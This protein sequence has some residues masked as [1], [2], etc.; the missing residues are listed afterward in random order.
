VIFSQAPHPRAFPAEELAELTQRFIGKNSIVIHE[1]RK[2][3]NLAR[4][5]ARP[6]ELILITGS[7]YLVGEILK[8]IRR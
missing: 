5:M 4:S 3:F 6:S 8:Y 2:A 7:F 1:P